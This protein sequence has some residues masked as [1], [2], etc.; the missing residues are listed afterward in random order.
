MN[1]RRGS[2]SMEPMTPHRLSLMGPLTRS[3][4]ILQFERLRHQIHIVEAIRGLQITTLPSHD[5]QPTYPYIPWRKLRQVQFSDLIMNKVQEGC[6]IKCRTVVQPLL[7]GSLQ[8]LVEEID[9][10]IKVMMI[11]IDNFV[12]GMNVMELGVLFPVGR[13]I[14]IRNPCVKS[15]EGR[16]MIKVDDP[17]NLK[18]RQTS[19]EIE[20]IMEYGPADMKGWKVKGKE[21]IKRGKLPEAADAYFSGLTSDGGNNK[22]QASLFRRRA[23]VL[24]E[25]EKYQAARR[26]ALSSLSTRQ[27]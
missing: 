9:G 5:T 16:P 18:L 6:M 8:A 20:R 22:L 27:E 19:R 17:M 11:S 15:H 2:T 1:V 3:E 25:L 12:S 24:Y 26:D 14:W 10:G 21:L 13:E 4:E 7:F 23:E